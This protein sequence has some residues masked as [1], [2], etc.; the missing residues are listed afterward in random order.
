MIPTKE[1]ISQYDGP[2]SYTGEYHMAFFGFLYG[3]L[4]G[5]NENLRQE[6]RKDSQYLLFFAV[7]GYITGFIIQKYKENKND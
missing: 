3:I 4:I 7:V 2:F 6:L 1:S 5:W